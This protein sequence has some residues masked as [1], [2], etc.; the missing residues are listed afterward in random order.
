[1]FRRI[2]MAHRT[3]LLLAFATTAF[4]SGCAARVYSSEPAYPASGDDSVVYVDTVPINIETYPHYYYGDGY[5]YY[6]DGRWYRRG[7]RGWGYYRQEPPELERRRVEVRQAPEAPRGRP[8]VQQAPEEPSRERP[9][10]QHAP[11]P[12]RERPYVRPAP[13]VTRERPAVQ[14]APG[15]ATPVLPNRGAAEAQPRRDEPRP[16]VPRAA[17]PAEK[18][19][20][21]PHEDHAAPQRE[22]RGP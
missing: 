10:V 16:K 8:Y 12:S 13:E 7:P 22:Q 18:R 14:P 15:T 1:M 21:E 3:Y 2:G 19:P 5:A 11:E 6:V 4:G 9:N 17:P 20:A